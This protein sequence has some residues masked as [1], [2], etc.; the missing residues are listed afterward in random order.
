MQR[1]LQLQLLFDYRYKHVNTDRDPDLSLDCIDRGAKKRFYSQVLLDP[2][3]E[4]FDLPTQFVKLAN[5]QRV[6]LK[7]VG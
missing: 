6:Q 5:S 7:V 1:T 2:F 3:E 4:Q